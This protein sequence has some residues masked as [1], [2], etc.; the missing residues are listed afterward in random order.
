[1]VLG[2]RTGKNPKPDPEGAVEIADSLKISPEMILYLGDT[3]VDMKTAKAAGMFPVGVLWGFRSGD[4]LKNNGAR[5]LIEK[6]QD[7]L[8]LIEQN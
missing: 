6:P 1:M 8:A 7:L 4:E 3:G 5:M 2:H